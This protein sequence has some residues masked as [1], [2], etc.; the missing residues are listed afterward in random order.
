[1]A[2]DDLADPTIGDLKGL[3]SNA[4]R[5]VKMAVLSA[6][7]E[8]QVASAEQ[9]YLDDVV[10]PNVANLTPMWLSSLQDF[11]RLRFEPDISN[12]M[13]ISPDDPL[14]IVYAALNRETLLKFY[15]E[16]WLTLVDAIASLIDRDSEFVFD[17]L[18]RKKQ[19][20]EPGAK[21]LNIDYRNEP[22]AFFFILYG[23]AFEALVTNPAS[24]TQDT[25]NQTLEILQALKKILRPS[26]SGHAI[27]QDVVFSET[28]ELFDRLAQTEVLAVQGA[29]VDI[30]CNLCLTHPTVGRQADDNQI[31]DDIEQL[32]ELTRIIVLVLTGVLPN[33]GNNSGAPP[34]KLSDDAVSLITSALDALVDVSDVFPSVIRTDLHAC[35]IHI[36]TTIL[37]TGAC[38]VQVVPRALSIFK[39]FLQ[40]VTAHTTSPNEQL[41]ICLMRFRAILGHAQR[42]ETELSLP[43]ARNTLL[44][45]TILLST[46]SAAID[47]DDSLVPLLLDDVLDC[48]HD[49]GLGRVAASCTHSLLLVD[50]G[51]VTSQNVARYVLPRVIGFLIG[52]DQDD[53]EDT[54]SL[55]LQT[56]SAY[57]ASLKANAEVFMAAL[58]FT[59]P[60][61]LQYAAREGQDS[62]S[63]V[64]AK[65][66][67]IASANQGA[68]KGVAG[69][70]GATQRALMEEVVRSGGVGKKEQRDE[71]DEP[72]IALKFTFGD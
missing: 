14:D 38:Q 1:V 34:Q 17:A 52:D 32:F 29:I 71:K 69:S 21:N 27:Y 39:R 24:G 9:A 48:L 64:A 19:G 28:M 58:S 15:Q 42:R 49:R 25:T 65:L 61:I 70:L 35:I 72:S 11:A 18:D 68:F 7:A 43:C 8:L 3:S 40:T 50:L 54:R 4:Q 41:R 36:F 57:T 53:P 23:I 33:L 10:K 66:L 12:S 16:T 31:S 20:D 62:Y 45:S 22:V 51:T 56:L 60:A 63:N 5:M 67:S 46:G 47:P 37:G 44:A 55:L 2:T 26:I 13:G 6:W 59:L 30:T